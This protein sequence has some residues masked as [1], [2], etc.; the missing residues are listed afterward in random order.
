MSTIESTEISVLDACAAPAPLP[1]DGL[2][3]PVY[4]LLRRV[5]MIDYP[6]RLCRVL[7][8]AGCNMRCVF[9]H[10][11]ELIEPREESLSWDRLE[12]IL[13]SSRENWVDSVTVT[14]GEPTLNPR[15]HELVLRLKNL[16]FKVKLDTNGSSPDRL[17]GL[18]PM[19]DYVAMDYKAP[20]E[21]YRLL[22]GCPQ[23][24]LEN[25]SRS[26]SIIREWGGPYEFRTTVV[27]GL[28]T[29]QDMLQICRELAGA[30]RYALQAYVP[31]R[32]ESQ[33]IALPAKRTPIKLLRH[34]YELMRPHFTETVL[35]GA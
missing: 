33:G 11:R 7:F 35:R 32:D 9:C 31:P 18:L 14:G 12:E 10:N 6:G 16:G 1:D 19:I 13:V 29:E 34:Y 2:R 28:H 17:A 5:S 20:L 8:L 21:R 3:S 27:P 23:L 22:T 4:A 30:R 24:E 15:L 25:I 26:V